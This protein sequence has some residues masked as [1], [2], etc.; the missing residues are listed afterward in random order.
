MVRLL[1][2]LLL[3]RLLAFF[4]DL[5]LLLFRLLLRLS[6][7]RDFIASGEDG[8]VQKSQIR[9][10]NDIEIF[11][12]VNFELH[13]RNFIVDD[14]NLVHTVSATL[15][16]KRFHVDEGHRLFHWVYF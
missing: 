4:S 9:F 11:H 10:A 8:G 13:L 14:W 1:V 5:L 12:L 16:A 6:T 7:L 3:L 2:L 15:R